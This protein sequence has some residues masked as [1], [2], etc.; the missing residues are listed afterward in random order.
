MIDLTERQAQLH[1]YLCERW[2]NPP[3]LQEMADHMGTANR[4]GVMCHLQALAAKGY[5]EKAPDSRSRGVKLLR[6]P[7]LDGTDINIA[8]RMYRL[9][10]MED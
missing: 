1:A 9:V 2:A 6:G 10:S 4:N 7:D 3:T 5:I 8:G